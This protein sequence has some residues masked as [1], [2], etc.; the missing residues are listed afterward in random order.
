MKRAGKKN[1]F[2]RHDVRLGDRHGCHR[3]GRHGYHRD[4]PWNRAEDD[5][6]CRGGCVRSPGDDDPGNPNAANRS[7]GQA[8][9]QNDGRRGDGPGNRRDPKRRRAPYRLEMSL[10]RASRMTPLRYE[11]VIQSVLTDVFGLIFHVQ[12]PFFRLLWFFHFVKS[13]KIGFA[14]K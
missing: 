4:D 12:I 3:D 10:A 8:S 14:S 2:I 6:G 7:D 9:R 1:L 5:P 13:H 11:R